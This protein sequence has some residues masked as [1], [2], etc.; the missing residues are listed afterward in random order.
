MAQQI[1]GYVSKAGK[2]GAY[3]L[4]SKVP[5]KYNE[6]KERAHL[7]A[8]GAD[9]DFWVDADKL[10]AAPAQTTT[11]QRVG[12]CGCPCCVPRCHCD[13]TCNC[14]GGNIYDC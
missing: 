5:D 2:L 9:F 6:G 12:S 13:Y 11:R 10:T 7:A 14:R 4:L 8:I 3:K 1:V